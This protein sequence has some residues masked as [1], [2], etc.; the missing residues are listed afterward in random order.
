MASEVNNAAPSSINHLIGQRGVIDQVRT[1]LDAAFEDAT[2]FDHALLVGGPGLG[3]SQLATVIAQEM[4]A[5]FREV[6]GQSVGNIGDLN[7]LLLGVK[8][9]DVI[10]IDECHELAKS[11]QTA[12]YLALDK[13]TIFINTK[14][15]TQGIPVADF[16][17]LL[18]T[19]DEYCLLQPLRDRMKLTLRFEFYSNEELS[20]LTRHGPK[21]LAGTS[22]TTCSRPSLNDLGGLRELLFDCCKVVAVSVV[23]RANTQSLSVTLSGR[24]CWNRPMISDSGR[25]NV[26][27]SR[28]WL[29]AP[30]D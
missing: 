9:K 4:A 11:L 7:A 6:L 19:T 5:D 16:T 8:D 2:R 1:A 14:N 18:S 21:L 15:S 28:F 10:H 26:S 25:W 22:R 27:T 3:K 17:L 29:M 20:S 13:Q 23:P 12:L 24:A 30:H